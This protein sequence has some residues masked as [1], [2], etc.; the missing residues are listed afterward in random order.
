MNPLISFSIP[1]PLGPNQKIR[2]LD[3]LAKTSNQ[4][5]AFITVKDN[6]Q[7]VLWTKLGKVNDWI[8]K[9][10]KHYWI[11]R[12][13][14]GGTHFH[15]LAIIHKPIVCIRKIHFHCVMFR[16]KN[17]MFSMD[18]EEALDRRICKQKKE[19]YGKLTRQRLM[20]VDAHIVTRKIVMM[21]IRHFHKK[22]RTRKVTAREAEL[23]VILKYMDKNLAEP[24][25]NKLERYIDYNLLEPQP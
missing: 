4:N 8:R 23:C 18:S 11:V 1:D 6:A 17:A 14:Q 16:S 10:S 15:I 5:I 13:T 25:P 24:R 3:A 21:I 12:G 9:Y 19:H 2:L 7:S 20:P 22:V